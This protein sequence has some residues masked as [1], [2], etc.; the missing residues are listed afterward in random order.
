[1]Q[2]FLGFM[3]AAAQHLLSPTCRTAGGKED[4]GGHSGA[5]SMGQLPLESQEDVLLS[6][7]LSAPEE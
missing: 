4:Q 1:M 2:N 7:V 6:C 5:E 3:A